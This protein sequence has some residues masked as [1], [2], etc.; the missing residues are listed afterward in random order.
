[1]NYH[2]THN[3]LP[4]GSLTVGPAFR[5]FSGW[6]WGA[7]LLPYLDQA[8]LYNQIDFSANTAVGPNRDLLT[9]VLPIWFCPSDISPPSVTIHSFDGDVVQVAAGNFMGIEPMLD[10]LSRTKFSSVTDGL[11]Q[12]FML[13]EHRYELD[14]LSGI[15]ATSSWV[16]RITFVDHFVFDS[17]PHL[18]ATPLTKIN[19]STI[20]SLHP[21]GAQF[22]FGDGSV[23]LISEFIDEDVYK[24]LG[25]I[26]GGETVSVDF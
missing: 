22:A 24:A 19:K 20:S 4:P 7:M 1:H 18:A 13:T 11:S 15:E 12:T 16:G 9:N 25:T 21:G 23:H 5:P 3:V 14:E 10:E 17:V 26:S 6:G 8:V 2:S